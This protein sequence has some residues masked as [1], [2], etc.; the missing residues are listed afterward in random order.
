MKYVLILILLLSKL[1]GY[2][3]EQD[4]ITKNNCYTDSQVIELSKI[5]QN[6]KR[7]YFRVLYLEQKIKSLRDS[8][9]KIKLLSGVQYKEMKI[10][11]HTLKDD[12]SILSRYSLTDSQNLSRNKL[13]LYFSSNVSF[14]KD[15][16]FTGFKMD[17]TSSKR[18]YGV[19]VYYYNNMFF[20][21]FKVGL[22]IF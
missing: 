3:Q 17:L 15:Y 6:E 2:S 11:L 21:N 7:L 14:R 8:I 13:N 10:N 1:A 18:I 9:S 4:T 19:G 12:T 20:Y 16:L 22:K 5:V